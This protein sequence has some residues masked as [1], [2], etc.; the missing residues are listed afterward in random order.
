MESAT[1][2]H[3]HPSRRRPALIAHAV[4]AALA[5][6]LIGS[7][8]LHAQDAGSTTQDNQ[9]DNAKTTAVPAK[10]KNLGAVTVTGSLIRR[11]DTETSNPVVTIDSSQ[12]EASGKP[13]LGDLVQQL[14]AV[15]GNATNPTIDNGGGT[16]A[17]TISLRGLGDN[18]TLVLVNGR[19]L[20]YEDVNSIPANMIERIEVLSDGASSVYGSDAIG[21]VVNFILKDRYQ[22]VQ[23]SSDYGESSHGDGNRRNF[24]VLAGLSGDRYNLIV[25]ATQQINAVDRRAKLLLGVQHRAVGLDPDPRGIRRPAPHQ[26]AGEQQLPV[27]AARHH[28]RRVARLCRQQHRLILRRQRRIEHEL[29]RH[30]QRQDA[31]EIEPALE[32]RAVQP[33]VKSRRQQVQQK[34]RL[35]PCRNH[36]LADPQHWLVIFLVPCDPAPQIRAGGRLGKRRRV[37]RLMRELVVF[38]HEKRLRAVEFQRRD[39]RVE[40]RFEILQAGHANRRS[41]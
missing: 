38:E 9:A 22:G 20:A 17:A 16:G 1:R 14:P 11:V 41:P 8:A 10:A 23:L 26:C 28:R 36:A 6:G 19:R 34:R 37:L 13:T 7:F 4:R 31:R 33:P 27:A 25:G 3:G 24:S 5:L 30:D 2:Q 40:R 12:I 21:G 15:A 35:L 18:R 32:H 29:E 39:R